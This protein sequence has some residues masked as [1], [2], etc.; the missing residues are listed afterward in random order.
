M[1]R[2]LSGVRSVP[3]LIA[4]VLIVN[5]KSPAEPGGSDTTPNQRP[6]LTSITG[7]LQVKAGE[8]VEYEA[9]GYDPDGNQIKYHFGTW[10]DG[11]YEEAY[12]DWGYTDYFNNNTTGKKTL[13][14]SDLGTCYLC[15]H[16][17]DVKG[18][19]SNPHTIITIQVSK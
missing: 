16:C 17:M 9:V 8:Q 1:R 6:I 19:D 18:L 15:C 11:K 3:L 14:F 13:S 10:P 4:V 5:C 12:T 2:L 7:P